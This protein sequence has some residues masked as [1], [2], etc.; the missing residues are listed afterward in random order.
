MNMNSKGTKKQVTEV[1]P[2]L[3]MSSTIALLGGA[4]L[5]ALVCKDVGIVVSLIG[6]SLG[7]LLVYVFPSMMQLG[8]IRR[9]KEARSMVETNTVSKN[10][11]SLLHLTILF[12]IVS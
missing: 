10:E 12:G 4:T 7:A 5:I 3:F 11:I 1:S 6:S 8:A 2:F 9:S